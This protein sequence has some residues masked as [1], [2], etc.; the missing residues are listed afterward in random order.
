MSN[1]W[2]KH[3]T[4]GMIPVGGGGSGAGGGVLDTGSNTNG[5]WIR[6]EN[7]VMQCWHDWTQQLALDTAYGG[8]GLYQGSGLWTF[9]Q[10]FISPPNVSVGMAKWASGASWGQVANPP[11]TTQVAIR[12][13]DTASRAVDT[14]TFMA[15]AI[16]RWQ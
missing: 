11:T 6:Y 14:V 10:A 13:L 1:L 9:P 7:G 12:A 8:I 4:F 16:G 5:N 15:S 3:P 2:L